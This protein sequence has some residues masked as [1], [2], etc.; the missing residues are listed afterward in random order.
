MRLPVLDTTA[1]NAHPLGDRDAAL[2]PLQSA[3][4]LNLSDTEWRPGTLRS[5]VPVKLAAILLV[6]GIGF[7]FQMTRIKAAQMPIPAFVSG[8]VL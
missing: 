3:H 7:P 5:P 6:L 2:N 4:L 1:L 8:L